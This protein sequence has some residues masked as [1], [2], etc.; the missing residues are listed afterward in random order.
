MNCHVLRSD[1]CVAGCCRH[2]GLS[3]W[4]CSQEYTGEVVADL[5]FV[6]TEGHSVNN[7]TSEACCSLS[8]RYVIIENV[9]KVLIKKGWGP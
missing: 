6:V 7:E 2:P 3:V 5:G 8:Y 9:V 4:D 1:L